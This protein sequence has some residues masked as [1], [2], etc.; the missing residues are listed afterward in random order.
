[1]KKITLITFAAL[2]FTGIAS[3]QLSVQKGG[4]VEVGPFKAEYDRPSLDSLLLF[5]TTT[6]ADS[7]DN[8]IMSPADTSL[9]ATTAMSP[10]VNG[11]DGKTLTFSS[12]EEYKA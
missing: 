1:M 2:A 11:P 12:S 3:A 9:S 10:L 6:A 5:P 7:P 8:G 4:R